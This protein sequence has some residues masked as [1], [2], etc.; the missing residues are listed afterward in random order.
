MAGLSPTAPA[1]ALLLAFLTPP[2]APAHAQ[3]VLEPT[4]EAVD[5]QEGTDV[6]EVLKSSV[7][8]LLLEHGTRIALQAK[9]RRELGG[10]FWVDY[11][12]AVR[13]PQQW[14]DT[15]SWLINYVGHPVHGA[16]AGHLWLE[17]DPGAPLGLGSGRDGY[18]SSRGRAT[19]WAAVYSLQFEVGPLSEASIGNVGLRPETV[20]WVDHVVTPVGAFGMLVAEDALDRYVV[21]WV[22]R[23]TRNRVVRAAVRLVL[24]PGRTMANTAAGRLPWHRPD[25]PIGW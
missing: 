12:R 6:F 8:L 17:H 9:T 25:R 14:G 10:N 4:F 18:W 15:D 13:M 11:H 3:E 23:K 7:R 2:V 24:N 21:E 19:A 22:E 20:G 16:A 5:D 1:L